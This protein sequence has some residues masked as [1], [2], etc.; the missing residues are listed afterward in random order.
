MEPIVYVV[1]DNPDVRKALARLLTS[2][3]FQV[4]LNQSTYEFLDAYNPEVPGCIV[5]DVAMPGMTG[6]E[7]QAQ[8][9][10][11]GVDCPVVFLTGRGDI[12]SSVRAMKAGA[13]DFLTKP[14]D[15]DTLLDAV[16]RGVAR[17]CAA[18]RTAVERQ[19][20]QA[21]LDTLTPREREVVPYLLTGRLN[22]QI[23]ADLGVAEKTIK[24]HRSR[25]MHKLG[26]RT[27]VELLTFLERAGHR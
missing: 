22:K 18:H 1:D 10:A 11:R 2:D 16:K 17:S 19:D 13:V 26:V 23:A 20:A 5:L 3:G 4:S 6:L 25:V 14:V 9:L 27:P 7:L 21:L 15:A 8:L 12:P 24:V